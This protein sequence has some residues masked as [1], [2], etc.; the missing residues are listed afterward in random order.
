M[1]IG[2]GNIYNNNNV[3]GMVAQAKANNQQNQAIVNNKNEKDSF[4]KKSK[5]KAQKQKNVFRAL[6]TAAL[7][8]GAAVGTYFGKGK[9]QKVLSN[10]KV[11][12]A[13][14]GGHLKDAGKGIWSA[15]KDLGKVF[16]KAA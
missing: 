10:H 7:V 13:D 3:P 16:K 8:I 6:G 12:T 4:V 11:N 15:L 1:T 2:L 14:L 9:I 5:T